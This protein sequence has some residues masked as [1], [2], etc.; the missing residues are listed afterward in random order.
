MDIKEKAEAICDFA[1]QHLN[2]PDYE[3]FFKEH[4]MGIPLAY[5]LS[6]KMVPTIEGAGVII[7]DDTYESVCSLMLE[8]PGKDQG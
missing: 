1:H 6:L 5:A 4:N 2:D 7:I 8:P 3:D